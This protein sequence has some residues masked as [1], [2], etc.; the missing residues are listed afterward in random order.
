M[1]AR[2]TTAG[3]LEVEGSVGDHEG[4]HP[5]THQR[6]GVTDGDGLAHQGVGL[7]G[8]FY[9][10]GPDVQA[11]PG[12]CVPSGDRPCAANLQVEAWPGSQ[13]RPPAQGH[14][15]G[16][17]GPSDVAAEQL[18]ATHP[19]FAGLTAHERIAEPGS[20]TLSSTSPTAHPSGLAGHLRPG[21]HQ[22]LVVTVG[23]S[24]EP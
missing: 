16:R 11:A 19:Q 21:H 18:R 13:S 10:G 22:V 15:L 4:G 1:P 7:E 3:R 12:G 23:A 8:R 2:R 17:L 9:L 20:A 14:D 6:V 24:V 5:L